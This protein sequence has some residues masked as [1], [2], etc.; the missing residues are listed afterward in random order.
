LQFWIFQNINSSIFNHHA[1]FKVPT[2]VAEIINY[3]LIT[4]SRIHYCKSNILICFKSIRT[5]LR[6]DTPIIIC[7]ISIVNIHAN[8][9]CMQYMCEYFRCNIIY[10]IVW[11]S[12][13]PHDHNMPLNITR[14]GSRAYKLQIQQAYNTVENWSIS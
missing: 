6:A 11:G 5:Q 14:A 12:D 9:K 10:V 2:T 8:D 4:G 3:K 1:K 7:A 13:G